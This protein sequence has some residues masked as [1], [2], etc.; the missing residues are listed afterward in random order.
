MAKENDIEDRRSK[1]SEM[2]SFNGFMSMAELV[3]RLSVSDS[4]IRRDLEI[5]EEQGVIRRTRGGAVYIKDSPAQ[6]LDFAE[7]ET[8][9]VA[10][11]RAIARAAAELIPPGQAVMLNGGTTCYEVARAIQGRRLSVITNS[12][13]IASVLSSDM[14]TEVT[15]IGGYLYPRTGVALGAMAE[16]H[17][18]MLH[19]SQLVLSC[20]GLTKEGAFN[21]NQMMVESELKMM[22]GADEIILVVDHGKMGKRSVVRLAEL[23]RFSTIVTDA[24]C[25][26]EAREW[27]DALPINVIYAELEQKIA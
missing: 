27:L 6:R 15:L 4:T 24:G 2:L 25:D 17:L 19:A 13:P 26:D 20:G 1:L 23:D 18:E 9:A 11:K 7:R 8:T 12:V 21:A 3:D 22:D 14:A 5:L 10:E 16:Q